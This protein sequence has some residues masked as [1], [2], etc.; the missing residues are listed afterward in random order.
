M[1]SK[2]NSWT[3][4]PPWQKFMNST[5]FSSRISLNKNQSGKLIL[6]TS[7][8]N[9]PPLKGLF[10]RQ[11]HIPSLRHILEWV[12]GQLGL[13]THG[14][15]HSQNCL[16]DLIDELLG[17]LLNLRPVESRKVNSSEVP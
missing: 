15:P 13:L 9:G 2:E 14:Q 6:E 10:I 11:L 5:T 4:L 17:V 16:I 12:C 8:V 7:Q 3:L 1:N